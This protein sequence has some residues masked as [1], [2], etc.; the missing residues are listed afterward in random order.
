MEKLNMGTKTS[1]KIT[2]KSSFS[3]DIRPQNMHLNNDEF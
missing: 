1:G 2:N 3:S